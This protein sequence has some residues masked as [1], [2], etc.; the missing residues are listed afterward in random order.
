MH[1]SSTFFR[2]LSPSSAMLALFLLPNLSFGQLPELSSPTT[3]TGTPTSA[4][5]FGGATADNGAS[6][7]NSFAFEAP[8][9]IDLEIKVESSHVN[10]LG[11]IYIIILWEGNYFLRQENGSYKLWDFSLE[12]FSAAFSDKTLQSVELINIVDDVAFGPAGVFNT[13]LDFIVA[14]DTL[15]V[16]NEFFFNGTP[17]SVNIEAKI[18]EEPPAKQSLQLFTENISLQIIQNNCIACHIIGGPAGGTALVYQPAATQNALN[19]NY[20]LLANY[21]NGGGGSTLLSKAQ[22]VGHGGGMRLSPTSTNFQNFKEFVE[23]LLTE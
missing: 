9:D 16:A 14:Y 15:A 22:G 17:L 20:N 4:R 13:T 10:T 3:L 2:M 12:N 5:F 19:T 23:V 18:Q 1:V 6:Y 7:S 21:I 8:I 11:N